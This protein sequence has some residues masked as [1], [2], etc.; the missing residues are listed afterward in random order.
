MDF[1]FVDGSH[2]RAYVQNDSRAALA[3]STQ[4]GTIIWHDYSWGYVEV[5][6]ALEELFLRAPESGI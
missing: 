6:K 3:L 5:P 1:V 4:A 2:P